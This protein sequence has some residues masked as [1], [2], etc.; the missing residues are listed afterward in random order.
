MLRSLVCSALMRYA[1]ILL[2]LFF[3]L[4]SEKANKRR[5]TNLE[6][7]FGILGDSSVLWKNLPHNSSQVSERTILDWLSHYCVRSWLVLIDAGVGCI[8][9]LDLSC[10]YLHRQDVEI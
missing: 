4:I 10:R 1:T 7:L 9:I 5:D 2:I 8:N 3:S 6:S